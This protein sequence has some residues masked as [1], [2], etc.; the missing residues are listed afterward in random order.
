MLT[1]YEKEWV[2]RAGLKA[3]VILYNNKY[4]CGYVCVPSW[5]KLNKVNYD[6]VDVDVHG[7][8]TFSDWQCDDW[9]F[10]FDCDHMNDSLEKQTLQ[11]CIN[12][13]ESLAVQLRE[14]I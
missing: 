4:R 1:N 9:A 13:C 11:Y 7:G 14:M 5:S 8:L 10:G 12:E 6:D 3:R 2:T